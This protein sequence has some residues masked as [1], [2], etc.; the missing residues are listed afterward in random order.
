[1]ISAAAGYPCIVH[2]S[3]GSRAAD[4]DESGILRLKVGY[5]SRDRLC[6]TSQRLHPTC[7]SPSI[8]MGGRKQALTPGLP[9]CSVS[10]VTAAQPEQSKVDVAVAVTGFS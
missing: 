1:M 9:H 7:L 8:S 5:G 2:S 6:R 10:T 4:V 3:I